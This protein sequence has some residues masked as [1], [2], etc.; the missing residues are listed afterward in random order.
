MH[1]TT[2]DP[3]Q[4]ATATRPSAA[5]E[6]ASREP[7]RGPSGPALLRLQRS[8]GNRHVQRVVAAARAAAPAAPPVSS[9]V[10]LRVG[11]AHDAHEQAADDVA[12]SVAGVA[13]P[14]GGPAPAPLM[15]AEVGEAGG[16]LSGATAGAVLAAR[17]GGLPVPSS[18]L[19]RT[20]EVLGA[21][22]GD[23]RLHVGGHVDA[24]SDALEARA[25]TVGRDVF[26]HRADYRPGTPGGDALLAHELAHTVQQG[27]TTVRRGR[28]ARTAG[29]WLRVGLTNV[30]ISVGKAILGPLYDFFIQYLLIYRRQGAALSDEKAKVEL[31]PFKDIIKY[32]GRGKKLPPEDAVKRYGVQGIGHVLHFLRVFG[33]GYLKRI[34][35]YAGTIG[36]WA[37]LVGLAPGMQAALPVAAA[38]GAVGLLLTLIKAGIDLVTNTWTHVLAWT[39]YLALGDTVNLN[40]QAVK[41]YFEAYKEYRKTRGELF[42]DVFKVSLGAVLAGSGAAAG[43]T[44]FEL[45]AAQK[46]TSVGEFVTSGPADYGTFNLAKQG[47]KDLG[48]RVPDVLP[49]EIS[50]NAGTWM[51]KG[52]LE[53]RKKDALSNVGT[54]TLEDKPNLQLLLSANMI[55]SVNEL[56]LRWVLDQGITQ[57]PRESLAGPPGTSLKG[58]VGLLVNPLAAIAQIFLMIAKFCQAASRRKAPAES[59]SPFSEGFADLDNDDFFRSVPSGNDEEVSLLDLEGNGTFRS[60]QFRNRRGDDAARRE[61]LVDLEGDNTFRSAQF[62]NRRGGNT[63]RSAQF[64][65]RRGYDADEAVPLLDRRGEGTSGSAQVVDLEGEGTFGSAQVVNLEGDGSDEAVSLDPEEENTYEPGSESASDSGWESDSFEL[66]LTPPSVI[67]DDALPPLPRHPKRQKRRRGGTSVPVA[68]LDPVRRKPRKTRGSVPVAAAGTAKE[69]AGLKE[70]VLEQLGKLQ[71]RIARQGQNA[72]DI[73]EGFAASSDA[74]DALAKSS[75]KLSSQ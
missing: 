29:K 65:N 9:G 31:H 56:N 18:L 16:V 51:S 4:T 67:P 30:G 15:P 49:K 11:P 70:F 64:R 60:A 5:P 39:R 43:G 14:D 33:S 25:F 58:L 42:D 22:L 8:Y 28:R 53:K 44:A 21:D 27:A 52:R 46:L 59:E 7:V 57:V 6:A 63:F 71:E 41:D 45:G 17:S 72:R 61:S 1:A 69:G 36:L 48:S 13:V 2:V 54:N 34:A 3:Q 62:R 12:R 73:G 37:G 55:G 23:V 38:C 32:Y 10:G 68:S 35:S 66:E 50:G 26:V 24:L 20:E 19:A 40:D 47:M 74:L 75:E